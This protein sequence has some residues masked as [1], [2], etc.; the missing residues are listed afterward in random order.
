MMKRYNLLAT[1]LVAG[2]FLSSQAIAQNSTTTTTTT[3]VK[4]P[5]HVDTKTT[6][7]TKTKH[8][9]EHRE[10]VA[11]IQ[12]RELKESVKAQ[13][14]EI[15]SLKSQVAA[16]SSDAATAQQTAA[17]AQTQAAA[18]AASAAEAQ[19]A[20]AAASTKVDSV[21]SS[22]TDLKSTTTGL[23]ETVV[24][25]QAH[26]EEEINEP[27][28]IH[29]KGITITPVAFFAAE[30]VF[31]KSAINSGINTPFNT[32]PFPGSSQ[33]HVSELNFSA[34][35]S[36]LGGLFA[37]E[38]GNLKLSGYFEA[39]FLSAGVT[40]NS[41]QSNS[42]TLRQRQFWGQAMTKGG[43]AATGGQM[44]SLVTETGVSTDARTEKLP[45]TIDPQYM[46]GYNWTRQPGLRLQ[47][48]FGN[49]KSSALTLA[50]SV[51]QA[52]IT[53][54][55]ATSA[56]AGA[57]PTN[58]FFSGTGTGGGLFNST[59]TYANN[60]APDVLVK[61]AYDLPKA[62]FEVGGIGRFLRD[63]Y[64]PI[65]TST[66]TATTANTYTY[67]PNQLSNTKSAGGIFG[68]AR[69]S[70]SP[71][72]TMAVQAMAGTGVG[73]Y[74]SSQLADATARPDGT[75][76][77]IRNYHGL[78]SLETHPNKAWD[79]FSYYGGEYAQRT[80]YTTATG[81][82]IGYGAPNLVDTGCYALPP[83]PGSSTGGSPSTASC[84]SPTRYIQ[85]G[86]I[87]FTYR[88]FNSPKI[89]KLQY[90]MTYSYLQRNLWSGVGNATTPSS[91]RAENSMIH[92]GMRYY[93]P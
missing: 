21:S 18:A 34:R 27:A 13:Q 28:K 58:F 85:E 64:Y 83:N 6:T 54:F 4:V 33:G 79:V 29:Y 30:G 42:Y 40:S 81:A 93:I 16:K 53:S 77:P 14:D 9:R 24:T 32:T 45:S 72:V 59:T 51:E 68:S 3:K 41:N 37:G 43:F 60:V 36:R 12:M 44:W 19:A 80:V 92:V 10:T 57:V 91:P 84:G 56:T 52:Q 55:T 71:F 46:V 75:L 86:M 31:R 63:Y 76:E 38:A 89:G 88:A 69:V 49:P 22:V 82:L 5:A 61:A 62:H 7:V 74:G 73:R 8:K 17:D 35:Q 20:A 48:M 87:G 2:A 90:S 47:Q 1:A 11:E 25:N 23:T 70:P 67:G 65:L 39:D 15:D 26:V 78:F 50:L 66:G